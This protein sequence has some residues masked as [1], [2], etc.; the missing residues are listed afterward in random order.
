VIVIEL[1]AVLA[2]IIAIAMGAIEDVF[3]L[4]PGYLCFCAG[5]PRY[6]IYHPRI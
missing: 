5:P 2:K 3:E 6:T 1:I 4:R